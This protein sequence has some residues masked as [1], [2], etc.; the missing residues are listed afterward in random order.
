MVMW[1]KLIKCG[2]LLAKKFR[3]QL[4]HVL[5]FSFHAMIMRSDGVC[6]NSI[7]EIIG[8][9][10]ENFIHEMNKEAKDIGLFNTHYATPDGVYNGEEYSTAEDVAKLLRV[11]LDDKDYYEIFTVENYISARTSEHPDGISF[12]N[13]ARLAATAGTIPMRAR[14][15]CWPDD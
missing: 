5:I 14:P 3:P 8:G 2:W 10:S 13:D 1:I 11:S 4:I 7:A 9:N 12:P 15:P 6:A